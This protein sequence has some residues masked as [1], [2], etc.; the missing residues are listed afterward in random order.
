MSTKIKD[1]P[2][3]IGAP[4]PTGFIPISIGSETYKIDPSQVGVPVTQVKS[5]WNATSGVAEILNKPS[6]PTRTSQLGNDGAD[7]NNP[8]ISLKDVQQYKSANFTA[9]NNIFYILG[10]TTITVTDPTPVIGKGFIVYGSQYSIVVGGVTYSPQCLIYRYYVLGGW[11][12]KD[13]SNTQDIIDIYSA[14]A[15][16]QNVLGYNPIKTVIRDTTAFTALT[17]TL[18]ETLMGTY[19]IPANTF[20]ANDIL[21]IPTFT[22]EKTGIIGTVTMRVKIGTTNVFGSANNLA[23]HTTN[24]TDL[25]CIM[26]RS[27]FTLRGGNIRGMQATLARQTDIIS[28]S[29]I[30]SVQTFNPAV[31]NYIF[32]SL[33]LS[34]IADSVFQ[35]NFLVTN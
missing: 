30:I 7:T 31:D 10:G 33:Q 5:D 29:G 9:E 24:A 3:Y 6:I 17:G 14:L 22:A 16:K 12:S 15:T 26:Q 35:S 28:T 18:T 19:L 4:Q 27:S 25:W 34:N 8:F 23:T 21:R 11:I 32:T 13:M 1:L 20:G 2:P